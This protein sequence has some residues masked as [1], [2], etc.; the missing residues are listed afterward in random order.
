MLKT[1]YQE[2][3]MT[4]RTVPYNENATCDY[5]CK[6][7]AWDFLGDFICQ[8][9]IERIKDEWVVEELGEDE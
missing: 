6:L 3:T 5:C 4:E 9:C 1:L 2:K 7:G 8:E